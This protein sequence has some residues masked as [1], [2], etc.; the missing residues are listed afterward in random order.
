MNT[1]IKRDFQICISVPL[2][3]MYMAEVNKEEDLFLQLLCI[4]ISSSSVAISMLYYFLNYFISNLYLS[5]YSFQKKYLF[6]YHNFI[7]G[8]DLSEEKLHP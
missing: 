3:F 4:S 5:N 1:D 6:F 7:I 2:R 8:D